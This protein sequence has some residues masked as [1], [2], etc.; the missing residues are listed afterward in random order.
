MALYAHMDQDSVAEGLIR[1][2]ASRFY[3]YPLGRSYLVLVFCL[4][5]WGESW[6]RWRLVKGD[7]NDSQHYV[8]KQ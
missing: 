4:S 7:V 1:V 3:S 6:R 8:I 2:L 5:V